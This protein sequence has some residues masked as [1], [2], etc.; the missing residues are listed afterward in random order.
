MSCSKNRVALPDLGHSSRSVCIVSP[1]VMSW[2]SEFNKGSLR[3][4]PSSS[5]PSPPPSTLFFDFQLSS[6]LLPVCLTHINS[7]CFLSSCEGVQDK[8]SALS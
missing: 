3:T 4:T 1:I 2:I 8:S 7:A 6:Y 5:I